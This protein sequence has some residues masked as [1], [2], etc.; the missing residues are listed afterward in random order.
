MAVPMPFAQ[1]SIRTWENDMQSTEDRRR[2]LGQHTEA[3]ITPLMA[4]LR[5]AAGIATLF[6]VAAGPWVVLS[7]GRDATGAESSA[8]K[9]A[10]QHPDSMEASRRVY[11][12][13]RQRAQGQPEGTKAALA[14]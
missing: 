12:E 5:C 10:V 3:P 13:R 9:S 11:E 4:V 1:P 8:R 7:A 14:K 6:V 2:L